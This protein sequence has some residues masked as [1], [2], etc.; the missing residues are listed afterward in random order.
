LLLDLCGR[1]GYA[2]EMRST[3]LRRLRLEKFAIVGIGGQYVLDK[4]IF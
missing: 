4:P 3:G 1:D 2:R